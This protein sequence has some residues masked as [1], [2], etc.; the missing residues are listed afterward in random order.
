MDMI[1]ALMATLLPAAGRAR[2]QQVRHAGEV[3]GDDA[4][5]DVLA[6]RQ[7]QF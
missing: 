5:V 4:A 1:M 2:N 7:R 6:Q 3:G